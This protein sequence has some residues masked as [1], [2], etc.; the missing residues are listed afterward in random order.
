MFVALLPVVL[1]VVL[2]RIGQSGSKGKKIAWFVF[3]VAIVI[4]AVSPL[5]I[6]IRAQNLAS[7][8][9]RIMLS[10]GEARDL[11]ARDIAFTLKNSAKNRN[12]VVLSCP[13]TTLRICYFGRFSG[14]GTLYWENLPG[15]KAA[16]ELFSTPDDS[17]ALD[18]IRKRG[19]SHIVFVDAPGSMSSYIENYFNLF[20]PGSKNPAIERSFAFKA[21]YKKEFPLWIRPVPYPE[22]TLT[23]LLRAEVLIL[24]IVDQPARVNNYN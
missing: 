22:N 19:I 15:L 4:C 24:E 3:C 21:F 10:L 23:R 17:H 16:A 8:V 12:I 2:N 9:K 14:I 11:L 5:K 6:I 7:P 13:N 20:Y 1:Y 18:L